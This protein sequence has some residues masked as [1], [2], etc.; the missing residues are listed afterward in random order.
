MVVGMSSP[1]H[2]KNKPQ[3]RFS[4]AYL[5]V[6]NKNRV[7]IILKLWGSSVFKINVLMFVLQTRSSDLPAASSGCQGSDGEV[8][9]VL[10]KSSHF[11]DKVCLNAC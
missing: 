11:S 10:Q 8:A 3:V 9:I 1:P 6:E 5:I 7:Q 2:S 4:Q